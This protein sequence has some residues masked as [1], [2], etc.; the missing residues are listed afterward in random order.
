M[1]ALG[2][3]VV[4]QNCRWYWVLATMAGGSPKTPRKVIVDDKFELDENFEQRRPDEG[5][6][7]VNMVEWP[8]IRVFSLDLKRY[9]YI[10]IRDAKKYVFAENAVDNLVLPPKMDVVVRKVFD[11]PLS[12]LFGDSTA[13]RHGGMII[14]ANGPSGVGKTLTAEVFAEHTRRP[15]YVMEIGELGVNL[16]EIEEN[17]R[18]VFQRAARWDA[19]MLLDEADVFMMKRD[20]NIERSAIVGVFLRLLDYYTGLLFLTT[21]RA[22]VLDQAFKSRITLRLDYPELGVKA[23][24]K[25]WAIMLEAAK[26]KLNGPIEKVTSIQLNGRQIRNLVRLAKLSYGGE[27][28]PKQIRSLVSFCA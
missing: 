13:G 5:K 28:T 2:D 15:L 1:L 24:T 6:E 12:E 17:L 7:M 9:V 10:D 8:Y 22:D 23:R 21:N 3:F 18:R 4:Q 26:I 27:M 19:V 20:D 25:V 11:T 14:L 16:E